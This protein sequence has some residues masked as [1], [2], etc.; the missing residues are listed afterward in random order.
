[1]TAAFI[2]SIIICFQA[3]V[4]IIQKILKSINAQIDGIDIIDNFTKFTS[5]K[6]II[7]LNQLRRQ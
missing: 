6:L 7:Y 3:R 2:V 1:V 5:Q 4:N